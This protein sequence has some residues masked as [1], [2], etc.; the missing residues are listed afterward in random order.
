MEKRDR[1][2]LRRNRVF[3]LDNI[4]SFDRLLS[5]LLAA[6]MPIVNEGMV[7]SI[8]SNPTKERRIGALLDL[9]PR[10][11]PTAFTTFCSVLRRT[12]QGFIADKLEGV[13]SVE[14]K[15]GRLTV[16]V[17]PEEDHEKVDTIP[18]DDTKGHISVVV[19]HCTAD[20]FQQTMV[21][22]KPYK[23]TASPR[24]LAL[25]LSNIGFG[26]E[27]GFQDR[28][29]GEIDLENAKNLL[30]GLGFKIFSEENKCAEDMFSILKNFA[31]KEEHKA[32]DACIVVLMSHGALGQIYGTDGKPVK[33]NDIF[34]VFNNNNCPNLQ[35]KPK[36][37]F[38][39]ACRGAEVDKGTD[40]PDSEGK[41][42]QELLGPSSR[43]TDQTDAKQPLPTRS[44]ML[45]SYAT[46]QGNVSF[47]NSEYGSWYI[48]TITKVFMEHAKDRELSSLLRM[49]NRFVSQK[50]ASCPQ[51]PEYH[52]GKECCE[53]VDTLRNDFYFFP[54]THT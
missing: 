13:T 54:G 51:T 41:Q 44:D 48:Q 7:D 11:G 22:H 8:Q 3:L 15:M 50:S 32:A 40:A 28:A 1:E 12:D 9:L 20:F 4:D 17:P 18:L 26:Q 29:G 10:R 23:M 37:F 21:K 45:L 47:R 36:L 25:I 27:S 39:Q 14:A 33:Y 31:A 53:Y 30:G 24:G 2:T 19:K 49:V 52:G 43:G 38:I 35:G 6:E 42:M 5:E 46:Q 16:S 34:E